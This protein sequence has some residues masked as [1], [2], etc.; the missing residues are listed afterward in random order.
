MSY[1]FDPENPF[2]DERKRAKKG[3]SPQDAKGLPIEP[4][5][6]TPDV[7]P[8]EEIDWETRSAKIS[9]DSGQAIFEQDD[10]EVP[11]SWS[12]LATKVVSSKYF[13]GDLEAGQRE[14]SVKQLVH[15][16]CR[17]IADRGLKDGYFATEQEAD[18]YYHELTWLCVNQYGAFNSPVWFNVGLYD[19][20]GIE[21]SKHNFRWD[22]EK[23]TAV[24]CESSYEYPAGVRLLHPVGQGFDGRHHAA[25]QQRSDA[26]Q[27]RI[28]DRNRL[29][30]T[31]KQQREA[32]RRRQAVRA[33]ELH[34]GLRPDRRGHQ[35]R[36]KDPPR[37][38]DAV[39]QGRPPRHQGIHH[40][41]DRRGEEGL[42]PDRSRLQRRVQLRSLRQ[43]DV[44][45]L[46]PLGSRDR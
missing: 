41:Q 4:H 3:A 14:N 34:A 31:E 30:N 33:A 27:A 7:H 44:P 11:T 24:P 22:D 13:Y 40:L 25:G 21:G 8:F 39:A 1:K 12:Q 46:Q 15:R 17:T 36:R 23:Q 16:V 35:V 26:L 10:I 9:S 42:G 43:R 28:R 18:T 37:R 29:I 5:F 32:L 19:V 38:Q 2:K 45:E 20:Y 6:S